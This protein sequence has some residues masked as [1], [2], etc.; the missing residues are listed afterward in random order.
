MH[1][2]EVTTSAALVRRLLTDQFPVWA[3]LLVTPV[4]SAGTDNALYRLGDDMVVRLP[5]VP[6]AVGQVEKEQ[7]WLPLLA[8][9]LP[10]TIP[11]P[12]AAGQPGHGYPWPWSV[13]GWLPGEHAT[14]ERLTD[15]VLAATALA[16]FI[17]A[18]RQ[19]DVTSGPTP[20]AHNAFRGVPLARR[21][22]RTRAAI[23]ACGGLVDTR[24][25]TA[26]WEAALRSPA[27][28]GPPVW[29]HGDLHAGNLL[30]LDGRLSAVIDFGCL[31]VGDPA[32]DLMV[33]WNFL[34]A[35]CRPT[36]RAA[37]GVDDAMWARGHGWALSMAL[38]AL[39]YYQ[40]SN[41]VLARMS[42]DTIAEV[43]SDHA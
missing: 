6:S 29:L 30:A 17:T 8:P 31:G 27:W 12:L 42:R 16:A 4:R 26:S 18:L 32:C 36:F 22:T 19:I 10:L 33:A 11:A 37:L 7:R 23:A 9:S 15:P 34:T 39:P 25:V 28:D 1:A 41:P 21:D 20:G 35:T 43:L 2:N 38:I 3:A 14:V 5:R 40:T 24:A 13:Y